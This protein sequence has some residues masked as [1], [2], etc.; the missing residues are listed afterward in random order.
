MNC[1]YCKQP[2]SGQRKF[3]PNCG[4][5]LP[6]TGKQTQQPLGESLR[7]E[8]MFRS[9]QP[10][11]Q[12]NPTDGQNLSSEETGNSQTDGLKAMAAEEETGSQPGNGSAGAD[13]G[14]GAGEVS[15]E[16]ETGN[17]WQTSTG[18][19]GREYSGGQ[20]QTDWEP[21]EEGLWNSEKDQDSTDLEGSDTQGA[22]NSR[23]ESRKENMDEFPGEKYAKSQN[24][25]GSPLGWICIGVVAAAVVALAVAFVFNLYGGASKE[26]SERQMNQV[27]L[28]CGD[29]TLTNTEFGYYYWSEYFYFINVYSDYLAGMLD[30]SIPLDEQQYDEETTWQDYMIEQ[31]LTTVSNTM[32]LVFEAEKAG[33]TL[34]EEYDQSMAEVLGSF[35]EYALS[36]GYTTEDGEADVDAYLQASY[37]PTASLESFQ[38]YLYNSYLAA[39]YSDWLFAEPEYTQEEISDYY[40]QYAQSYQDQYGVEKSEDFLRDVRLITIV[41]EEFDEAGWDEAYENCQ[42][43]LTTWESQGKLEDDFATLA[44]TYSN[45]KTT[46]A[47]G[48]LVT[49]VYPGQYGQEINDWLFDPERK[50]GD[51]EVFREENDYEIVYVSKISDQ[52]YWEAVAEADLRYEE[53]QNTIAQLVDSYDF[54]VNWERIAISTPKELYAQ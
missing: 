53:Y 26:P 22:G 23:M 35:Q 52:K 36:N 39:A 29:F 30:T 34:D 51:C 38:E 42:S 1:P 47:N 41:P 13:P 49:D 33:F 48:G 24:K 31:A 2:Y 4:K 45:D 20:N 17:M 43:I 44:I 25:K 54:Q 6:E 37:G 46:S 32:A 11:S 7:F 3:C 12:R 10:L 27:M 50:E 5:E 15:D 28:T 18:R 19:Q 14:S 16:A 9:A 21:S 40:D 8:K